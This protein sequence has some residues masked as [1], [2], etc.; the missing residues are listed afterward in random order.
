[1]LIIE[2]FSSIITSSLRCVVTNKLS[3]LISWLVKAYNW[4]LL[5]GVINESPTDS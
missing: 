3:S 5:I 1:M 2:G 4:G